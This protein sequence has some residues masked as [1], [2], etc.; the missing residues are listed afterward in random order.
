[1]TELSALRIIE[2]EA[3]LP[4]GQF[5]E[6]VTGLLNRMKGIEEEPKEDLS[7]E[8]LTSPELDELHDSF[9]T[10]SSPKRRPMLAPLP[11]YMRAVSAEG[12]LEKH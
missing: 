3:A 7:E 8:D 10:F 12:M 9:Q 5:E 1:M 4:A 6:L 11:R 2:E